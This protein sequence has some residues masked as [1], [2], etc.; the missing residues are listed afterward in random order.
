MASNMYFNNIDKPVMLDSEI[1]FIITIKDIKYLYN[2]IL[3][4]LMVLSNFKILCYG[5]TL[6]HWNITQ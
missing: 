5:I 1:N 4:I 6:S 2:L 3:H